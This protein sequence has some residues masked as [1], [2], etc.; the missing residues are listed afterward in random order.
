MNKANDNQT[1]GERLQ[2]KFDLLKAKTG[3]KKAE[4]ARVFKVPGGASMISQHISGNRPI[5]LDAMVAYAKGFACTLAE[6]SPRLAANVDDASTLTNTVSISEALTAAEQRQSAA[7]P[8]S[9][10]PELSVDTIA[11][12]LTL[13][14]DAQRETMAG[15]LAALARAPDSP[16]LKKSISESLGS[17][18]LPPTDST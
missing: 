10:S 5:S 6:I 4:F 13:M 7:L 15:K 12:A 17:A 11:Q 14:T 1:D 2:I 8:A 16:T 18:A 9:P 3:M